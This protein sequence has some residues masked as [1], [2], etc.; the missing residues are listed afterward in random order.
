MVQFIESQ[1]INGVYHALVNDKNV[2][3][4]QQVDDRWRA[5]AYRSNGYDLEVSFTSKHEAMLF[6]E[7]NLDREMAA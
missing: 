6:V 1:A 7:D 5:V 4:I 3:M 2:G